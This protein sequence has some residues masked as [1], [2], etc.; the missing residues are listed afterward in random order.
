MTRV[1]HIARQTQRLNEFQSCGRV[2]PS[3][4]VVPAAEHV[5]GHD[6]LGQAHTLS[7]ASRD[8]TDPVVTDLRI[9]DFGKTKRSSYDFR[10]LICVLRPRN[11][12][13]SNGWCL[14]SC[15][16][17]QCLSNSQVGKMNFPNISTQ[18]PSLSLGDLMGVPN[19]PEGMAARCL[20][21]I[22]WL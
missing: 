16:E 9:H 4:A 22:S 20:L 8:S 11:V 6:H 13:V 21:S 19:V 14:A 1:R 15:G 18:P 10:K 2:Q 17:F 5:A 12:I 3:S 7:L